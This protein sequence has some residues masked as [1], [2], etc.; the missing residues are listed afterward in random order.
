MSIIDAQ[1]GNPAIDSEQV[2]IGEYKYEIIAENSGM[3]QFINNQNLV[4][5]CRLLGAPEL[6]G[7]GVYLNKNAGEK[8]IKGDVLFT[9]YS[10]SEQRLN[11]AKDILNQLSIYR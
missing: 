8:Y 7:S 11:S 4:E 6:K 3:I 1:G 5:I 2:P 10:E 9:L